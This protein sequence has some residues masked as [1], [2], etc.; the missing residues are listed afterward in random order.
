MLDICTI[1]KTQQDTFNYEHFTTAINPNVGGQCYSNPY[2]T[3]LP[4]PGSACMQLKSNIMESSVSKC[5][6]KR[7]K[8]KEL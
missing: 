7:S 6:Q 2:L 4:S 1:E 3:F 5:G 8:N